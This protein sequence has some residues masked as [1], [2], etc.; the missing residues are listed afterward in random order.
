MI[1]Q[2]E[3]YQRVVEEYK[4]FDIDGFKQEVTD[5]YEKEVSTLN[6]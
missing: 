4:N 5:E 2:D 1:E 3:E 6:Q